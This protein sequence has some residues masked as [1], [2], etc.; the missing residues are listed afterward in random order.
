MSSDS[1]FLPLQSRC[2]KLYLLQNGGTESKLSSVFPCRDENNAGELP[3]PSHSCLSSCC[4]HG[5]AEQISMM[6]LLGPRPSRRTANIPGWPR[7]FPEGLPPSCGGDLSRL[8]PHSED[9]GCQSNLP[10]VCHSDSALFSALPSAYL[11]SCA[12]L[13]FLKKIIFMCVCM[14]FALC[15]CSA[16]RN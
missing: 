5:A 10:G 1:C 8:T 3:C 11:L 4:C 7:T 12:L 13:F 9:T 6:A 16:C 15:V 2:S 14:C